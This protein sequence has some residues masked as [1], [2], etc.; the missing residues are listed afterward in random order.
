MVQSA[1]PAFN[2]SASLR[3]V[4]LPYAGGGAAVFHRWRP[5]LPAWLE[6]APVTLPGHDGRLHEAAFTDL[7]RLAGALADELKAT[8]SRPYALLG[9]SMGAWL[10]FELA[11]QLRRQQATPSPLRAPELLVVVASRPPH[12]RS[13]E[14]PVHSLPA[15]ELVATIDRRYGAIPAGVRDSPELLQLLLP[16]L[17]A[18]LHMIETYQYSDEPP[19]ETPIFAVG[20]TEDAA[21]SAADLAEWRRHTTGDFSAR[22]FPG[23]HFFLFDGGATA[24]RARATQSSEIPPALRAILARLERCMPI[25][26]SESQQTDDATKG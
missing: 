16:A 17:R 21:V 24:G 9:Y 14:P 22:L 18:D 25:E 23:G 19:L 3:L 2:G 6:I 4:C 8:L 12:S 20:G 7:R 26:L 10:A 11:R 1:I 5:A 13:P 15:E